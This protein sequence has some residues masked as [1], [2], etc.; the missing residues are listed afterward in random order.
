[1]CILAQIPLESRLT[2]PSMQ[3]SKTFQGS[4]FTILP[5]PV[6][7]NQPVL[8][9]G[10]FSISP[11][12]A[13]L[14]QLKEDSSQDQ[15]PAKWN[16]WLLHGPV[17][18]AWTKLLSHL[19]HIH[20]DQ[21]T[22]QWWPQYTDSSHGVLSNALDNVVDIVAKECLP[23]WSTEVG[24]VTAMDGLLNIGD[25]SI[26]LRQALEEAKIPV[27]YV[28]DR[29]NYRVE[30][31]FNGQ[32]LS[33][34]RLSIFL[35]NK[36]NHV[37]NWSL[38]TKKAILE[39]ILSEPGFTEYSSIELFPFKDGKYRSITDHAAFVH[40]KEFEMGLFNLQDDH[41]IDFDKL[42]DGTI[43]VLKN[44]CKSLTM[45]KSIRHRS[46]SDFR[47]YCLKYV[48]SK[49]PGEQDMVYL[50]AE[51]VAFVSRAWVWIVEQRINILG[52]ISDLWLVPM[53][54]GCHRKIKPRDST[55]ETIFAPV[56]SM[57]DLMRTFD[58]QSS[59]KIKPLLDTSPTGLG[60]RAREHLLAA[61]RSDLSLLIR[62]GGNMIDFAQWLYQ[63]RTVVNSASDED[64]A[65]VV[66]AIASNLP[67]SLPQL[68]RKAIGNA[69]GA[70]R[71]FKK[72]SWK[73]EGDKMYVNSVVLP[74]DPTNLS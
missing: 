66:R 10:L 31:L 61:A 36:N 55:S 45:H 46:A 29:L 42:S 5:L 54:N 62:N 4:L 27:I 73:A 69:I 71:I 24:H 8:I 50:D 15:S 30:H 38:S 57:G 17:P 14:Y 59:S 53:T 70:L 41:N 48:F 2:I 25:K 44:G 60:T 9:H 51:A 65:K 58:I 43:S 32:I 28:P 68:D 63:I 26:A 1:M 40:R 47:D 37:K 19:A 33:P 23:L 49:I 35:M 64:K 56:G 21:S 67:T 34:Q 52:I 6:T 72:V 20:S 18:M 16:D 39:Y 13:R 11:D 74:A 22:F 12:R 7:I 3:H